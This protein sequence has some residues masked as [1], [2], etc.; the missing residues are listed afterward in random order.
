M[1]ARDPGRTPKVLTDEA[2]LASDVIIPMGS[3]ASSRQTSARSCSGGAGGE[4]AGEAALSSVALLAPPR[5][6]RCGRRRRAG[7]RAQPW[8]P[9]LGIYHARAS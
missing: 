4:L 9:S 7:A 1:A 6:A 8:S 2:A 5:A 3:R